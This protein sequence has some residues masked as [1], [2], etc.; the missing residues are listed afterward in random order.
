MR[1]INKELFSGTTFFKVVLFVF[2][3]VLTSVQLK[4]QNSY[5]IDVG[6]FYY[7][8]SSLTI[9][10]GDTVIWNNTAGNHNINANLV[11]FPSNPEGFGNAVAGPGWSFQWIFTLPGTY[12][13]QCDPHAPGM[14]GIVIVNNPLCPPSAT[15]SSVNATSIVSNDGSV[16]VNFQTSAIG[17]FNYTLF[18]NNSSVI[19]QFNNEPSPSFTFSSVSSGNYFIYVE[20]LGCPAG[21]GGQNIL[22]ISINTTGGPAVLVGD[23]TYC[24]TGTDIVVY[25]N[26]C[27]S[28]TILGNEFFLTDDLGGYIWDTLSMLDSAALPTLTG[29]TYILQI[30]N[31]DNNCVSIDTFTI[32]PNILPATNVVTNVSASGATDGS[33]TVN[34]N[35]IFPSSFFY[36]NGSL[37]TGWQNGD[38]ISSLSEGIYNIWVISAGCNYQDT[39]E[40]VYNSCSSVLIQPIGCDPSI[41]F[42][43]IASNLLSGNYTYTYELLF[44][45]TSVEIINS[46]LDSI[47]FTTLV[48]DSGNYTL[49]VINDST[50]CISTSAVVLNLNTMDI[51]LLAQNNIS[52]QGACDGFVSVDVSGG[53]FPYSISWID[54]SGTVISGPTAPFNT[55]SL[56]LLC[57]DTYCVEVTD[58]TPCTVTECYDIVF[59]SCNTILTITDSIDC[60]NGF[61]E[62]T[63]NLDTIGGGVGPIIT[64]PG[65]RY[66]YTLYSL[67][68]TTQIGLPIL[69]DATS[70][71]WTGLFAGSYLV[72]VV[73][74][75]YGTFC[76][77]DSI[78]LIQPNQINIFV[79]VDSTTSPAILDGS[80]TIDSVVGGTA[81]YTYQWL[82][83][84]GIPFS[85]SFTSVTGLGYSNQFNGGYTLV[86][87]DTNGCSNQVTVF[88]HPQNSGIG[89]D[90][91]STSVTAV[92]CYGDCDG[93]LFM[94]TTTLGT[95]SVPPFTYIWKDITGTI[96]KIDSLGSPW[97]NPS[98]VATYVNRC[99]GV[100]TLEV[101]DFYGNYI[102]PI[103]FVVETPDSMSVN[104]GPD[105]TIDCGEDTVLTAFPTGGNLTNDTTLVNTF[106]LDF[107]NPSGLGDTLITGKNY[108]LVVS[109]S[110]TDGFGNSFDA[111]YDYTAAPTVTPTVLWTM[112][113]NTSQTPTPNSYN[114]SHTYNY[115]FVA[116][117]AGSVPGMGIHT[118]AVPSSLYNGNLNFSLYQIDTS[119]NIYNYSW[120]TIPPSGVLST[121]DTAY[122]YPGTSVLG[123]TYVVDVEDINGCSVSD[124]V[125]VSWNLYILDFDYINLTHVVPC[126]GNSTGSI[127]VG[128]SNSSGF[129]T[130]NYS[131]PIIDTVSSSIYIPTSDTTFGLAAGNYIFHLQ[132]SIGCLSL[133]T[134]VTI[135]QPD[136][137]WAC[138]IG[139][140]NVK[141]QIDN[142]VMDFDTISSTFNHTSVT[143]TLVGVNYLLVVEGTYGLDFFNSNQFDAAY[144][145]ASQTS[146]NN[147]T[148]D[149]VSNRPSN[150]VYVN[151]HMYEY[152]FIG[153]GS[154]KSFSFSDVNYTDNVGDL[155]FTLYKLGCS[156]TDTV[157]T[158]SG[159]STAYSSISATGGIPFLDI[160]GNA[161][162]NFSWKDASGNSWNNYTTSNGVTSTISGIPAGMYTVTI[163]DAN[164]CNEYERYLRVL[165]STTALLIDST[166]VLDVLC[167]GAETAEVKVY[168]SGGFGPYFT[169]LTHINGGN[170]DTIYQSINDID[171]VTVDSLVFGNYT[172][173]IYDS[174]PNNLNGEYFCPQVFNFNINQPQ[175]PMT[176]VVNLLT[177]VSCWGDT[178]GKA[179]VIASGGQSQLPYT[180][181]WDNGETTATA[182]SLWADVN[183]AWPSAEWQGLTIT[184]SNGC[185]IRDS[186]Q[187]EHIN[188]EIQAYNSLTGTNTVQVI[189]DVQCFNACDAVVTVSSVGGILP[190]TYSWSIGNVGSFMPDTATGI[191]FGGHDIIIEDQVGCRKTVYYQISQPDE[192]F[193]NAQWV[194]H[195]DCYGYDNGIAHGTAT[196]GT[197]PY[198]FVWDSLTGQM[199]DTAFNLTP[200][201]HTVYVIDAKGCMATDTVTI[202]EPTQLTI[203]IQDTSTVYSYCTGTNSATLYAIAQGGIEPYNYVWSDVLGQTTQWADDL[204]AGIYIVTVL[205]DRGCSA[206]DTRNIDSVTNTM[207]AS[208]SV[209][210]VTCFN[211]FDGSTY[212][213]NVWGSVAP[214]TYSW[215]YPNGSIVTQN[216]I[217][218]LYAGNYGVTIT[219]S[220]NCSV[221][222]Y[223]NVQEPDQLEYTL[224]DVVDATCYGAC[225]GSISVDVEG[226]TAPY[227]WDGDQLG[228]FAFTN[229]IPLINDSLILD[230]CTDDYEIYVTDVNDCIGTVLWGGIWQATIDSGVVVTI[231]APNVSQSAS[232]YNSADG[233]ATVIFPINYN[234]T[235][236]WETLSGVVVDTGINTTILTGGD[237]NLV[238]HYSDSAN[239]GQVYTGC[240]A[241][242]QFNMPSPA[243]INPNAVIDPINCY[244]DKNGIINI[245]ATNGGDG[246]PYTYQWDTT[247]SLPTGSNSDIVSG[248]EEGTYTVTIT[249]GMGCTETIEFDMVEPDALTNNFTNYI[250]VAC[251]G[252]N[253]GSVKANISG[254]TTNYSYSWSPSGGNGQ[255]GSNLVADDYTVTVTD[256]RGCI[257]SFDVTM[258]EPTAIISTVES[259]AF[260]GNDPTGTIS[261]N[262]SCFGLSDGAAIVSLGGGVAPLTYAWTTG[263]INQLENNMP[264]GTHSVTVTDDNGCDETMP[265][266]L[267]EPDLLIVNGSSSGD[268]NIF[269]GGFD[270][271]CKGLNDGEI[272]A[273]PYGGVPGTAGYMYSWS[274]PINGQISN[275][276]EIFNLYV[277]TYSVT[278]TDANGCIDVQSFTLT[279][280]LVEFISVTHLV[281]YAGAGVAPVIAGFQD[282]T[283]T[284]DA[285]NYMFYWQT[286]DSTSVTNVSINDLFPDRSFDIIGENEVYI[287]VQNMNSGCIDD[288]TFVIEVQGIPEIHNVFTPNG[289]GT[290]DYFDFGEYAMKSVNVN[291]YNRW[292]ELVYTWN[293]PNNKWDGRGL[294]GEDLLEG[295]YYYVLNAVGEDGFAYETKGS[296]TLLR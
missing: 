193:A 174:L 147:W 45:G 238:A 223:S 26:N 236:T 70:N 21:T 226:G 160:N 117:N 194:D 75:S 227:S 228:N 267:V 284:I 211:L 55:S 98:H 123:T 31:L 59:A 165:E 64:L 36:L 106:S 35:G 158:C 175:S 225:N 119:I 7:N 149:G 245:S 248:L 270:I 152:N 51:N 50:G 82:D 181:L 27:S 11:D 74:N 41:A 292:G 37:Q 58:A 277:G 278:V 241:T 15:F 207:D 30:T 109:G 28:P 219:D 258:T 18:D 291:L 163:T 187:I 42:S 252:E 192:L 107:N 256:A 87:T 176:S 183:T 173:Y 286:G 66:T 148:M 197:L 113:G 99:A 68:P 287:T 208:T 79:T 178:T 95:L 210:D 206:S 182:D 200:G 10:I 296:I 281:N 145:I 150:D 167:F 48:S 153:D 32:T 230:L 221:T 159:D 262:I 162:Y 12:N 255:T 246:G 250:E 81:P 220:N 273:D 2:L 203:A 185:S 191:C 88:L 201:V 63:A 275:L 143:P 4:S 20:D 168:F 189:Q 96:L 146:V 3:G 293:T 23:L 76:T 294:D 235:Y 186:I 138:G 289:D 83:S 179:K 14:S 131:T 264:A 39:I 116:G 128:A 202:T 224:F 249:D 17:P 243:Q 214:Y 166:E 180:Y 56:P 268:Y 34:L 157:Y 5:T 169:V 276:D 126:Y 205:D 47:V 127:N 110:I 129:P 122:A 229:P 132:D 263:G 140:T 130:Y 195:V 114:N 112:D 272:Y 164:G 33:I 24:G 6:N 80:I 204:L 212:V 232:C 108:L 265:I 49:Q 29:G 25:S 190:H 84:V 97:Y 101:F 124:D 172:L 151:S 184:D 9:N 103:E 240:D 170:I 57:E 266:T 78:T 247:T 269:P 86:V 233:H 260:Y 196:G 218:F 142:F 16:S 19:Q 91:D 231:P 144:T 52:V 40:I 38:T 257:E 280:P 217:N 67:N 53:T 261:Y 102:P 125:N 171:S 234:Y 141:Y 285:Y 282:E 85:T 73:D 295:V 133:D 54:G 216:Q 209:T 213:D 90:L 188:E 136:S 222:V 237:Y 1:T 198:N 254:G 43:A 161:Y 69:S 92:T 253:N 239:F 283:V 244:E 242:I 199:N 215:T 62:I 135:S 155:T 177:H 89:F 120:T 94:K 274:G 271:S 111:A 121:A 72:D 60:Y 115:T 259:N 44:E 118:W 8:P 105:F 22:N 71:V 100:Y 279:E 139:N 61:G 77:S 154:Q 288:T 65:E 251:N 134:I 46:S 156:N 104:L 290:N 93:K 137:I 13:Y